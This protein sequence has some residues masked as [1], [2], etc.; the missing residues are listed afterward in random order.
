MNRANE[1]PVLP[2]IK[3]LGFLEVPKKMY[4]YNLSNLTLAPIELVV[5]G[6]GC[7]SL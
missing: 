5:N 6:S 1:T 4:D 2:S 3:T 7:K